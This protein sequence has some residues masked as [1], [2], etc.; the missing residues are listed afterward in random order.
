LP[1]AQFTPIEQAL[2]GARDLAFGGAYYRTE[3]AGC[4]DHADVTR[5]AAYLASVDPQR[6]SPADLDRV[7]DMSDPA[8]REEELEYVRQGFPALQGIYRQASADGRLI[9]CEEM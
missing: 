6:W 2:F 4:N 5:L 8:D 1:R 3:H 7:A 9:V